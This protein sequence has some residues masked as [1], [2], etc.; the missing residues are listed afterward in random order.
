MD[1]F[2]CFILVVAAVQLTLQVLSSS[3]FSRPE[4]DMHGIMST[5]RVSLASSDVVASKRR[6]RVDA[7]IFMVAIKGYITLIY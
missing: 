2:L 3:G 4:S 7:Y 5:V 6:G 1:P